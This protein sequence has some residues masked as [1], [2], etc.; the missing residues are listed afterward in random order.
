MTNYQTKP[1]PT[2]AI[3]WT[4]QNEQEVRDFIGHDHFFDTADKWLENY[5]PGYVVYSIDTGTGTWNY[6]EE[7]YWIIRFNA[8]NRFIFMD[9]YTFN[10]VYEEVPD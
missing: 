7:G 1:V 6:I 10:Q 9:D 2:E 4:G 5:P 8:V 3:Q